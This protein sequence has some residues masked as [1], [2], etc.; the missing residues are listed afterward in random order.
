MKTLKLTAKHFRKSGSYWSDYVG[1]EDVSDF[2]GSIEI[3]EN[4][5]YV[6]FEKLSATGNI[7]AKAGSGILVSQDIQAGWGL[8]AGEE[9]EA[10]GGIEAGGSIKAGGDIQAGW[11]IKA[12][13]GIE[14]GGGIQAGIRIACKSSLTVGTRIFAGLALWKEGISDEEKTIT[15]KELRS[16]KVEYGI[17]KETKE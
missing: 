9:I 15:C 1:S 4:L 3:E 13:W 14:A 16:G 7:Y 11:S 2:N 6:K 8:Q 17:L 12:G 10:V 5:G